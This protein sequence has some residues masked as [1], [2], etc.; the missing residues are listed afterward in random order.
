MQLVYC[1]EFVSLEFLLRDVVHRQMIHICLNELKGFIL[2]HSWRGRLNELLEFIHLLSCDTFSILCGLEGPLKNI[3]N[4]RHS[5]DALSH[6]QA[7][8]S[9][10]FMIESNCPVLTQEFNGIW[11]NTLLVS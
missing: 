1:V 9:E 3:L 4:V 8:V 6:S 7:E 2:D 11:N 5:L 10:P